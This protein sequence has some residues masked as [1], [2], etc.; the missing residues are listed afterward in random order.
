MPEICCKGFLICL[1]KMMKKRISWSSCQREKMRNHTKTVSYTHLERACQRGHCISRSRS[2][3][4]R[5]E[6]TD[7][8][9][10]HGWHFRR[11]VYKRQAPHP[12]RSARPASTRCPSPA[13]AAGS[14]PP[15]DTR[16]M[17]PP[18]GGRAT[19]TRPLFILRAATSFAT[20]ATR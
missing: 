14:R 7:R 5:E 12:R 20:T 15:R 3:N 9:A 4:I 11:D 16:A 19:S 1:L 10:Q 18:S 2:R 17:F 13:A 6:G 8:Q